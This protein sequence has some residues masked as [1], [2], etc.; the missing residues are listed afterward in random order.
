MNT[1]LKKYTKQLTQTVGNVAD[2]SVNINEENANLIM[3]L[4][5]LKTIGL[6]PIDL[7][8]IFNYQNKNEDGLFGK[9]IRLNLFSKLIIDSDKITVKNAD[10]S[11]DV[12]L[13]SKGYK[14]DENQTTIE[15]VYDDEYEI[16]YHYKMIDKY[17]NYRLY[18]PTNL[19]YPDFIRTKNGDAFSIEFTYPTKSILNYRGDVITFECIKGKVD[20]I[21]Y[22][23]NDVQL[24]H[25]K[26]E[27]SGDNYLICLSY[28]KGNTLLSSANIEYG[29]NTVVIADVM[30]NYRMKYT[31]NGNKVIS[32]VDSHDLQFDESRAATIT[33]SGHKTTIVD[34]KGNKN[35]VFFDNNNLPLFEMDND[36]NVIETEYDLATKVLTAKSSVVRT[37][38]T[39]SNL[40][41]SNSVV[42]FVKDS[43][44]SV[45]NPYSVSSSF[46][47]SI[48]GNTV[49]K[50]SGTGSLSYSVSCQGLATDSIQ[51]IIW[52]IN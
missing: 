26:L 43:G 20:T 52:D 38:N 18:S 21:I 22:K 49:C 17:G 28:F 7:S 33:Y 25:L 34:N 40:F 36:G 31:L 41:P 11:T 44:V 2:V 4:P 5:L 10:G 8:L 46:F 14:N 27:Y 48:L 29:D 51:A 13:S 45:T 37:Q 9:G 30:A 3:S 32:F 47:N 15:K 12:Y 23:H 42:N 19:E 6:S 16:S 50:I 1:G 35:Y 39:I 24:Y